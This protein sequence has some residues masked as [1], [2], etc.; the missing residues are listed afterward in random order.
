M[1]RMMRA[2]ACLKWCRLG[3]D[4]LE[5]ISIGTFSLKKQRVGEK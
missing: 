2:K 5:T 3:E 4:E 1:G